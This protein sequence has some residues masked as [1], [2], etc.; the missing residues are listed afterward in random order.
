[1]S[2]RPKVKPQ[3][4]IFHHS[5]LSD[6]II[7]TNRYK[8]MQ[9]RGRANSSVKFPHSKLR[10]RSVKPAET[11]SRAANLLKSFLTVRYENHGNENRK[12]F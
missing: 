11:E 3:I 10:Q 12:D 2:D 8:A 1:M 5:R 6:S 4:S 9:I 7:V